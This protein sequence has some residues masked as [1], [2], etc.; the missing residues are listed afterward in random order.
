MDQVFRLAE[1]AA[2]VLWVETQDVNF[3]AITFY[4]RVGFEVCGFDSTLYDGKEAGEV[5]VFLSRGL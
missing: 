4:R 2:R 5:A 3:P 1:N